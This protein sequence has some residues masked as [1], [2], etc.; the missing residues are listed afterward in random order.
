MGYYIDIEKITIDE[1][2]EKL[3]SG[4]L[5]PSRMILK[6][7]LDERFEYF[8]SIGIRN[9]KG[10][11]QLLKKKDKFIELSAIDCLSNEYLTVLLRELKSILPKPNKNLKLWDTILT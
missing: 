7:K 8:K 1:Y 6:D 5:P 9:V 10:L 3:E 4:Y 2:R 11:I